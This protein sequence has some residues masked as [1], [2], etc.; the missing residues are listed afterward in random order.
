[1]QILLIYI[2]KDFMTDLGSS[3]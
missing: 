3:H 2:S 1:M